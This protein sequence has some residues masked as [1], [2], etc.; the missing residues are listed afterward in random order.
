MQAFER[1]GAGSPLVLLHGTNSSRGIWVPILPQLTVHRDVIVIDLPGHG[2]SAPTSLTPAGFAQDLSETFDALGLKA[3]A[4]VGHSV[5][6]WVALE[7]AKLG[8]AGAVLALA[9]AGLWR[10][11]SPWLT[12]LGLQ[13]NW[14]LGRLL[15]GAAERSLRSRGGRRVALGSIS[16]R[17]G[18]VP[19]DV[20]VATARAAA[21]SDHFPAHFKQTRVLR[22]EGGLEISADVPVRIIWGTRT[23]SPS[24][25]DPASPRSCRIMPR[26]R[27]G[28]TA[29]IW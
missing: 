10:K 8:R 7:L 13:A 6:G 12:D 26:L 15:P 24:P 11:H 3:P 16:A 27:R 21:T 28:A 22:F 14:H 23:A 2:E 9:P 18:D 29:V 5:G 19:Y 17:P 4:V 25:V 1:E 20:A